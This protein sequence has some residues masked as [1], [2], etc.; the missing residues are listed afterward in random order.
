MMVFSPQWFAKYQPALLRFANSRY[1]RYV[2]RIHGKRSDVGKRRITKIE[3]HAI[4]WNSD[5]GSITT[6][7]RS[8][9]KYS[10]RLYHAFKPLWFAM[11]AWDMAVANNLSQALNLGFDTLIQYPDTSYGGDSVDGYVY[12]EDL[13]GQTFATLRAGIGVPLFVNRTDVSLFAHLTAHTTTNKYT[14]LVRSYMT[15]DTAT[16]GQFSTINSATLDLYVHNKS[17][18]L[19]STSLEIVESLQNTS[20]TLLGTDFVNVGTDSFATKAYA[21]VTAGTYNTFTLDADGRANID[22]EGDSM[23]AARLGWDLTGTFSGTWASAALTSIRWASADETGTSQD[24]KLTVNYSPVIDTAPNGTLLLGANLTVKT[25]HFTSISGTLLIS[26]TLALDKLI[27]PVPGKEFVYRVYDADGVY[28]GTWNDVVDELEFTQRLNTPGTTTTVR[29]ARSANRMTETRDTLTDQ[30]ADPLTTQDLHELVVVSRTNN[31]VGEDSDVDLNYNVDIYA[32]YGGFEELVGQDGDLITT[33]GNEAI[34]VSV[35]APLG[36]RVFSGFILDYNASYG[37]S[38]FVEV[39]LASHGFELSHE[40]IKN[41]SDTTRTYSTTAPETIIESILDTNPGTISYNADSLDA[42]GIT[43]TQTFR[44]NTKLEGIES[45]YNQTDADWYWYVNIGDN[46]LY[47][48]EMAA[49]PD[50]TFVFGKHIISIALRRSIENL[51][52]DTYFVG[53][54][55]GGGAILYKR[56]QDATSQTN[57][58]KGV[59]RITDRRYTIAASAQRRAEKEMSRYKDPIYTTEVQIASEV[60]DIE[61]IRL[62]QVI[63]FSNF[64]NFVDELALQIVSISYNPYHVTLQLGELLDRQR[65]EIENIAE[66][67]QGEQFDQIPNVPS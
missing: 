65:D 42:T 45:V 13:A 51:R 8:H 44:L 1:G 22:G 56:Y 41:G 6:E 67:V 23:F 55:T 2:L 58:R 63:G 18:G 46:L 32:H 39:T 49:T 31:T 66:D 53:G 40:I 50:H 43:I 14:D 21:S 5:D 26:E 4:S 20:N 54:D 7:F 60:Y 48:K 10:K 3:P 33:Q 27:A 38:E 9:A 17:N 57:W 59:H 52:N 47:L 12:A 34:L 15:F 19:G 30:T 24:P 61:T 25:V 11:H 36:T 35:G 62:G 64:G 16:I 37:D 28:I 29:L